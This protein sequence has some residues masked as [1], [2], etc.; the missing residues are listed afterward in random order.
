MDWEGNIKQPKDRIKVIIE[1][2]PGETDEGD[3]RISSVET[4]MV[5]KICAARKQWIDEVEF[6]GNRKLIWPYDKVDQH[7]STVSS[8]LVELLLAMRLGE[9]ME[10]GHETMIIGST[11]VGESEYILDGQEGVETTDQTSLDGEN[12]VTSSDINLDET[13]KMDLD[14]FVVSAIQVGKPCGLDAAH[15]SKVWRISHEDAQ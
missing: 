8:I 1:D 2:L 5:D 3:Y 6:M 9:R 7:L 4:N 13:D 11:T 12:S 15:L 14:E 10:H